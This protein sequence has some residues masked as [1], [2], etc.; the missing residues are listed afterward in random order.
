MKPQSGEPRLA[1]YASWAVLAASFGLSASSWIA[2]A[3]VAGFND[4]LTIP[5]AGVTL[6]SAWLMPVAADGYV[7]VAWCC[8]WRRYPS[9]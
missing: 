8:G 9:G 4:E 2:L 3:R 1:L 7:V 5:G 6:A